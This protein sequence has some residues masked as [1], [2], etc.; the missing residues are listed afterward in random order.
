MFAFLIA[1][2][3]AAPAVRSPAADDL[4]VVGHVEFASVSRIETAA[5]ELYAALGMDGLFDP[6]WITADFAAQWPAGDLAGIDRTQPIGAFFVMD[7]MGTISVAP[8]ARIADLRAFDASLAAAGWSRA[9]GDDGRIVRAD[10]SASDRWLVERGKG[11]WVVAPALAATAALRD[12]KSRRAD[13]ER[14]AP[15]VRFRFDVATALPRV[16]PAVRAMIDLALSWSRM[17]RMFRPAS[18]G[19]GAHPSVDAAEMLSRAMPPALALL[20][21]WRSVDVVFVFEPTSVVVHA[22]IALAA[23]S[24]SA[25]YARSMGRSS[26]SAPG[27]SPN[28]ALVLDATGDASLLADLLAKAGAF[29]EGSPVLAGMRA[30][31]DPMHLVVRPRG[32]PGAPWTFGAAEEELDGARIEGAAASIALAPWRLLGLEEPSDPA[33]C[34]VG[35]LVSAEGDVLVIDGAIQ[36]SALRALVPEVRV[37]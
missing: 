1:A 5:G 25:A 22:V 35:A 6:A 20:A 26:V 30:C 15:D 28:E 19:D 23:D 14:D 34:I 11:E 18:G 12:A 33:R 4:V 10:G 7:P 31:G 9:P 32:A 8:F 2:S 24:R 17:K 37:R 27:L 13:P 36:H 21:D 3:L 16:A 29:E